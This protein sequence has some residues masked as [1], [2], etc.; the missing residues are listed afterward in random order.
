MVDLVFG[1]SYGAKCC[2]CPYE[3]GMAP[4]VTH[5]AHAHSYNN[6]GFQSSVLVIIC[7]GPL[8]VLVNFHG[9]DECLTVRNDLMGRL[10][11]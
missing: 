7:W 1:T 10:V 4:L 9:I 2:C 5:A 6:F 3:Y 11:V 8:T